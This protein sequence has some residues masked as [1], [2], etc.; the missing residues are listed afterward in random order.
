MNCDDFGLAYSFTEAAKETYLRGLTTSTSI[1]TNGPAYKYAVK[2]LKGKLKEIGLGLHLN[3]TDGKTETKCLANTDGY[4]KFNFFKLTNPLLKKDKFLVLSVEQDLKNQFEQIFADGLVPDHVDS[5]K[6][7]HMIPWIF[8]IVCK[9]CQEYKVPFIRFSRE[10]Y[11]FTKSVTSNIQP[12]INFNIAKIIILNWYAKENY[13]T[14]KKN[15]MSTTDA[16]YGILFTN[17]MSV[18]I[19]K[20]IINNALKNSFESVEIGIHPAFPNDIR[21]EVY[22]SYQIAEYA[23]MPNRL[24][25]AHTLKDQSLKDF[26]K[27]KKVDLVTYRQLY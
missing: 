14:L 16:F 24:M 22:T 10:P 3:L 5:E 19:L 15:K 1:R 18:H 11:Y 20:S 13:A 8:E 12:L 26:L 25:E 4:Y 2:L 6:H 23:N 27:T 21:D 9:L 7:V 17:N